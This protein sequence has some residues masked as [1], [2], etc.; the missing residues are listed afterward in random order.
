MTAC[1][2]ACE[3]TSQAPQLSG[4]FSVFHATTAAWEVN[5]SD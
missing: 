1:A 3:L 2:I 5:G 4:E